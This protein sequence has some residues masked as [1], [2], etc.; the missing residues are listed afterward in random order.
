MNEN[1]LKSIRRYTIQNLKMTLLH[2]M[3]FKLMTTLDY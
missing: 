1:E 3:I 2:S